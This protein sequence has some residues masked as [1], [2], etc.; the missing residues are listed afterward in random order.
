MYRRGGAK[1]AVAPGGRGGK[2]VDNVV[3]NIIKIKY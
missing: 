2:K 3:C 1:G